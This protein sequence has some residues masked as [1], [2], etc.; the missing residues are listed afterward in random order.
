MV[1]PTRNVRRS[2]TPLQLTDDCVLHIAM[3]YHTHIDMNRRM[4]VGILSALGSRDIW[5]DAS[6]V[7]DLGAELII[8]SISLTT[9]FRWGCSALTVSNQGS[10]ALTMMQFFR[11]YSTKLQWH[12]L[13]NMTLLNYYKQYHGL[14]PFVPGRIL[15]VGMIIYD[16]VHYPLDACLYHRYYEVLSVVRNRATIRLMCE[17]P[18]ELPCDLPGVLHAPAVTSHPT[19]QV[20]LSVVGSTVFIR[21]VGS[22]F[23]YDIYWI[24]NPFDRPNVVL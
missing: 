15:F 23:P 9:R 16:H 6:R 5:R 7:F 13:G 4:I 8:P 14:R 22:R 18:H 12:S 1:G 19:I 3:I 2:K 21:K 11:A 24:H 20:C 10:V 17:S